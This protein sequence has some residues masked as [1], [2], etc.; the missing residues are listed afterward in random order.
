MIRPEPG[1]RSGFL[2]AEA[3]TRLPL[4]EISSQTSDPEL[5][6]A[7]SPQNGHLAPKAGLGTRGAGSGKDGAP[8]AVARK[9]AFHPTRLTQ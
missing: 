1:P 4:L 8:L 2:C 9:T 5:F 6:A 3:G 7:L